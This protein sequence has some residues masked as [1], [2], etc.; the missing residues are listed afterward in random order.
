MVE[1][2]RDRRIRLADRLP[3]LPY[4]HV[5]LAPLQVDVAQ[6]V[7]GGEVASR[8]IAGGLGQTEG[9]I[10]ITP[11]TGEEVGEIVLDEKD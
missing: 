6:G 8:G 2:I 9:S 7:D 5:G 10:E 3:E 1:I 11:E 4:G